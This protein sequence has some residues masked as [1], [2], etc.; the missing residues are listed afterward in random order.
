MELRDRATIATFFVADDAL[1]GGTTVTLGV[2]NARHLTVRRMA[3]GDAMQLI[4]GGGWIAT[5]TLIRLVR[6]VA[7]AQI[8]SV[9][10]VA[11]L[12]PLHLLAPIADRDRMLWLAEKSAEL[13]LTSWR[14]V[15]WKRSRSVKP[16]GEG[17]TFTAKIRARMAHA[18]EQSGGAWLPAL[19]PD[20]TCE[21][22]IAGAPEG[23]RLVLDAGGESILSVRPATAPATLAVGPEGGFDASEL[24]MLE[25]AGFRRVR[26]EGNTLRFETAA[27]A[28]MAVLRAALLHPERGDHDGQ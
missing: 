20:A 25:R 26:L 23:T 13:A 3:P 22:A 28:G 11:P 1:L 27:I 17:P 9:H 24:E 14:P 18:L 10:A 15:L 2:E 21:R 16:R 19:Y 4:N 5:A 6:D 12:P 7:T 8:E